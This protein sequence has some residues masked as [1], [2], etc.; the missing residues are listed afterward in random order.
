M[1]N[2]YTTVFQQTNGWWVGRVDEVPGALAQERTLEEARESLN[3][4][5]HDIVDVATTADRGRP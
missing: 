4:A 5:L 3:E 2:T 1:Q